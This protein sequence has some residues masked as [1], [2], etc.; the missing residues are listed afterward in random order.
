MLF[1]SSG[2][3]LA[4]CL[5]VCHLPIGERLQS[6]FGYG[7]LQQ[8]ATDA[9]SELVTQLGIVCDFQRKTSIHLAADRKSAKLLADEARARLASC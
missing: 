5:V 6:D 1:R 7:G 8:I 3:R 2:R 9:G 4:R